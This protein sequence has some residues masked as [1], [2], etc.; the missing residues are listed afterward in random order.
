MNAVQYSVRFCLCNCNTFCYCT[1]LG[2]LKNLH[3]ISVATGGFTDRWR[4]VLDNERSFVPLVNAQ[5]LLTFIAAG[6]KSLSWYLMCIM[7]RFVFYNKI[8]N[9]PFHSEKS[10]N[11]TVAISENSNSTP[12]TTKT[13]GLFFARELT[14]YH[15]RLR[16]VS[17]CER[18]YSA[19]VVVYLLLR[20]PLSAICFSVLKSKTKTETR[21]FSVF[22]FICSENFRKQFLLLFFWFLFWN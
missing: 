1:C 13:A 18:R 7:Q 16:N 14:Q 12:Y 8:R 11:L 4:T 5:W 22:L 9:V 6:V 17:Y 2:T 20:V 15:E 3:W 21:C 19:R 10:C